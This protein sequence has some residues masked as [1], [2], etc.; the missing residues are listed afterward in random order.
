[1]AEGELNV[2]GLITRLQ[3]VEASLPGRIVQM[4]EAEVRGLCILSREIFLRQPILLEIEAPIKIC[5][6]IHGHYSG[7]LRLFERGG[8]PPEANYLFLGD[9]VDR[10][11]QSLET[12]CLLLAYKIKYP[13]NVF[14][15]RGSHECASINRIEGF[16]DECER[17]FNI[18][19]WE[20]FTDCFN[21]LPIV[22]IIS[23]KIFCCHG[24]L[25][26]D[27][28]NMEQIRLIMRP[29]VVPDTGLLCDLL[30]S[31]PDME[32]QGWGRN[33][34]GV[35]FTFGA[36]VVDEFLIRHDMD[37]I[38]RSHELL[39]LRHTPLLCVERPE[40]PEELRRRRRG[41]RAGV[42][43]RERKRRFKPCLPSVIMGNVRSLPNN[44]EELTALTRLQR[45]YRE[46]SLMCFT[47]TWLTELSPDSHVNLDGFQLVRADRKAT[48]CGK[49]KGGGIA[50]LVNDRWC[51]PAHT[52]VKEMLCTRDLELLALQIGS[53][54][55]SRIFKASTP[56][57]S[58]SSPRTVKEWSEETSARLRDCFETTDWEAL[59]SPHGT[60]IDSMTHC[61]TDY[62]NF[63]EENT[64][65]SK[66]RL[67]MS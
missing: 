45:E 37:L 36:D 51:H 66:L 46:C 41:C 38:C 58:S 14:L 64:V 44:M 32:G 34:R 2:D 47:E 8:F 29:T 52:S 10:G 15:L 9:Y 65:P 33:N 3:E 11:R 24:G 13:E 56:K 39:G 62:I 7:L 35:S 40:I 28:Q 60:D 12:I 43:R 57:P 25:S 6:N 21:C 30:W 48:E 27:L 20:T 55:L 31:D 53:T 42:K 4:T 67:V 54:Q 63:C 5:G 16:Y 19:I 18:G 50:V 17:R 49:K 59:C 1:M 61:I 22:A 23:E 26:P